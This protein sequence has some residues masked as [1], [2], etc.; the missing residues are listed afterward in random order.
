MKGIV[1][2]VW[3]GSRFKIWLPSYNCR[4]T[5]ILAGVIT[6]RGPSNQG[7][8]AEPFGLESTEFSTKKVF[9]REVEITV[10]SQDK[11]GGFIGTLISNQQNFGVL[12]LEEG[13]AST[14]HYSASQ[15]PAA[16][17]LFAAESSAKNAKRG[18]WHNHT[19][20]D[21]ITKGT[22]EITVEERS[23]GNDAVVSEI[24]KTGKLYLQYLGPE[25]EELT[26]LMKSFAEYHTGLGM[27]AA[28]SF[29][30]KLDDYCSAQ[31]SADNIWY[32]AKIIKVVEKAYSVLYIDYGNSEVVPG[33]RLRTL[34]PAFSVSKL[35]PQANE[36]QLAYID[37]PGTESEFALMAIDALCHFTE[38]QTL[39][40]ISLGPLGVLLLDQKGVS[41][42]ELLIREGLATITK[43]SMKK[44]QLEQRQRLKSPVALKSKKSDL[45]LL[46]EA[47]EETSRSRVT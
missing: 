40:A 30:P 4:I 7:Q 23:A 35:K 3:S 22:E 28:S 31:F 29:I 8:K 32:R 33:P 26:K 44:Y 43:T 46:V 13:F 37:L 18:I 16:N 5:F 9:Q 12:L 19:E 17:L 14:H 39:K 20:I 27:K 21:D 36:A 2:Y 42:Q 15:N 10:E 24:G 38:G 6:P 11:V 41:I 34:P 25:L 1:E 47:Q 45:D